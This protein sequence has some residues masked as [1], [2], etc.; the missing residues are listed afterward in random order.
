MWHEAQH[1]LCHCAVLMSAVLRDVGVVW[2]GA[3]LEQEKKNDAAGHSN[4]AA[5]RPKE[6][7]LQP[8][9]LASMDL[10]ELKAELRRRGDVHPRGDVRRLRAALERMIRTANE[11]SV[12]R[13]DMLPPCFGELTVAIRGCQ[14]LMPTHT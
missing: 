3:L 7:K 9:D 8:E 13:Q 4:T 10:F 12:A 14:D 1:L 6:G 2:S 11:S 5:E